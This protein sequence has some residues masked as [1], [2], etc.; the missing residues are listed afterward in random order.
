M[1][2]SIL[3]ILSLALVISMVFSIP[4]FSASVYRMRITIEGNTYDTNFVANG[5]DTVKTEFSQSP[6]FKYSDSFLDALAQIFSLTYDPSGSVAEGLFVQETNY[7]Y[8]ETPKSVND[9]FTRSCLHQTVIE[10]LSKRND[11]AQW[12]EFINK[13]ITVSY[14]NSVNADVPVTQ[15]LT[16]RTIKIGAAYDAADN[17]KDIH[18]YTFTLTRTPGDVWEYWKNTAKTYNQYDDVYTIIAEIETVT[19]GGSSTPV[20]T[21]P[22]VVVN[23]PTAG[24]ETGTDQN[25]V[26]TSTDSATSGS[27]IIVTPKPQPGYKLQNLTVTDAYGN[28]VPTTKNPDGTFSF[29]MPDSQVNIRPTFIRVPESPEV[30]GTNKLLNTG[31]HILYLIGY[32]D[33]SVQPMGNITR[34]EVCMAFYRLLKNQ[35]VETTVSYPDVKD[36]AWFAEA[37]KVI[38]TLNIANGYPDGT[39]KPNQAITR[40]EFTAIATRFA[41]AK[42]GDVTFKDVPAD[43]WAKDN[44]A[45]AAA[46]GWINGYEDGTYRPANLITRA[47]AAT[48]I[49]HMLGRE[50]D[51]AF[52]DANKTSLEQF[53]DLQDNSMWYYYDMVEAT[54]AHDFTKSAGSEIWTKLNK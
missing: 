7:S 53:T 30:T 29:T 12:E 40:A 32:P 54:N 41:E 33:G 27:R 24:T 15:D 46:Y 5:T 26:D 48:I 21:N 10:G 51:G 16:D 28:K 6:L 49:N 43:Y 3:R 22:V 11:P 34:A 47:E 4:V 17:G 9:V 19:T 8:N 52:A 42:G 31:D 2:R 35:N 37:V 45:T 20:E 38:S 39:F 50:A 44:I 14:K 25:T 23:E 36:G 13:N 18:A 1:K